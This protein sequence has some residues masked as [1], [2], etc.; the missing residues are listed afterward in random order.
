MNNIESRLMLLTEANQLTDKLLI[1]QKREMIL[2]NELYPSFDAWIMQMG[3][4][5]RINRILEKA[6]SRAK[7]RALFFNQSV[8]NSHQLAA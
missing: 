3:N 8:D 1:I 6:T 5:N 2:A 7:R 4:V